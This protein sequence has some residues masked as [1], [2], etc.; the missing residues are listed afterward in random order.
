[1]VSSLE[2]RL[3]L[4][5]LEKANGNKTRAAELLKMT[6]SKFRYKLSSLVSDDELS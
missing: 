1:M 3:L 6:S 5:A 2:R 4:E